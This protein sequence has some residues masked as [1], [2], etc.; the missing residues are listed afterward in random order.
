MLGAGTGIRVGD[1]LPPE[2]RRDGRD[3]RVLRD[4]Q[5][6]LMAPLEV[7]SSVCSDQCAEIVH[8]VKGFELSIV[9]TRKT[10]QLRREERRSLRKQTAPR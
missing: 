10:K 1:D 7:S 5:D 3:G 6:G 9:H 2:R 8:G 4:R